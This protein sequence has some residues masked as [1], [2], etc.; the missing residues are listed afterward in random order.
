MSMK[1]PWTDPNGT[2]CCCELEC[3]KQSVDSSWREIILTAEEYALLS[4]GGIWKR[5]YEASADLVYT[6][7]CSI[8]AS[9]TFDLVQDYA[10]S[11]CSLSGTGTED[12]RTDNSTASTTCGGIIDFVEFSSTANINFVLFNNGTP[13]QY[14]AQIKINSSQNNFSVRN[15]QGLATRTC[16]VLQNYSTPASPTPNNATI[17]FIVNGRSIA[18]DYNL[19]SVQTVT[20]PSGTVTGSLL[21]QTSH[22]FEFVPTA[23]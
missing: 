13:D 12:V 7:S 11:G 8:T 14:G 10:L 16:I 22:Y 5:Y 2:P 3:N 23:P 4:S 20:S 18:V 9:G 17:N 15:V 19:G 21:V 1:I 6:P